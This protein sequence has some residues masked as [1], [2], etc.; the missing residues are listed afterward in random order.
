MLRNSSSKNEMIYGYLFILPVVAG[1]VLFVLVPVIYAL[2]MSFSDW[3]LNENISFIGLKNYS[4]VLF[5]DSIFWVSVKNTFIFSAGLVVINLSVSMGLAVLLKRSVFGIGFFRTAIFTPYITSLVIWSILWKFIFANELG[6]M[7]QMLGL[8]GIKGIPWL[9]NTKTAMPIV[10]LVS[11]LKNVGLNMIIFL[12]AMKNVPEMYY[13]AALI[14][15]ANKWNSFR[16]I[17]LPL[18]TPTI[19]MT[20]ILTFIGSLKVFGQILIMTGGGPGTS[21]YVLVFYIFQKA[22]KQYEFGYASSIAF[23]LFSITLV[24]TFIQ[25]GLRKRWVYNEE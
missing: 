22:F 4:D 25:W 2:S 24:F 15:G 13:E 23:I 8:F 10:I 6:L 19:F 3:S 9:Y 17:T 18:I 7:N 5:N 20:F 21:T 1:F 11:A 16:S 14:D 12:S